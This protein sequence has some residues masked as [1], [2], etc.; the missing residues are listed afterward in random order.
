MPLK[1]IREQWDG[2]AVYCYL[3][4][5][6]FNILKINHTSHLQQF[7]GIYSSVRGLSVVG[8]AVSECSWDCRY[9]TAITLTPFSSDQYHFAKKNHFPVTNIILLKK[10]PPFPVTNIILLKS[11]L[12]SSD[13]YHL[14]QFWRKKFPGKVFLLKTFEN[15][16]C[17]V[18]MQQARFR[19]MW[20]RFRWDGEKRCNGQH[21]PGQLTFHLNLLTDESFLF[22]R[23]SLF[24]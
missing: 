4:T 3:D 18:I 7:S 6:L 23:L 8:A 15:V 16:F 2:N 1:N 21:C 11:T 14:W 12:F 9:V 19:S 17:V 22:P 20:V 5:K 13:Q 24:R 10:I